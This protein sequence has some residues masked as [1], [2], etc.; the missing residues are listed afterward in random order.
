MSAMNKIALEPTR[1]LTA[2]QDLAIVRAAFAQGPSAHLRWRLAAISFLMDQFDEV[3][4]LLADARGLDSGGAE[5]LAQA[6]LARENAADDARALAAAQ[7]S[8]AE[9][10]EFAPRRAAALAVRAKAETRLGKL[11]AAR[12]TLSDALDLDPLN[13]DACKRLATLMLQVG[14]ASGVLDLTSRLAASGAAHSRLFAARAL[15]LARMGDIDAAH[16]A[17]GE[18]AFL[19]AAKLAPPEGWDSIEAFNDALADELLGHPGLRFERYGSASELTWRIDTPLMRNTP[20]VRQLLD[21]IAATIAARVE[22][23]AAD[24][25]PWRD[26]APTEAMLRSW[27]VITDSVGYETW[28]VHQFGWLSGA[29]YVRVPDA[30]TNG[31]DEAGCIAIGLPEDI[32]GEEAAAAFGIRQFRPHSG[33]LLTFPSHTYH[34]TFPHRAAEQRICVAFDLRPA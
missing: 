7:H 15:A 25:H 10:G 29:Y 4:E 1:R 22:R 21:Q 2:T 9:A 33:L 28:H 20:L 24:P 5:L 26:S 3:I 16:E 31:T 23:F 13:K 11:E 30:I 27:C 12:T 18:A 17:M 6:Y 14:D 8:L 34:R 19:G 32:V